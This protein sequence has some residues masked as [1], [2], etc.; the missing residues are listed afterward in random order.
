MDNKD[1]AVT[2]T[3]ESLDFPPADEFWAGEEPGEPEDTD[4]PEPEPPPWTGDELA[5]P[6][7]A[8]SSD[9]GAG[10]AAADA[11]DPAELAEGD[12]PFDDVPVL[13]LTCDQR[14][15]GGR[16]LNGEAGWA[17][18]RAVFGHA[19]VAPVLSSLSGRRERDGEGGAR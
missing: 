4:E 8:D 10:A 14:G 17:A 11:S 5:D 9:E 3:R 15:C 7:E 13:T 18:H 2:R 1:P 6:A 19:P 16:Y 12:F